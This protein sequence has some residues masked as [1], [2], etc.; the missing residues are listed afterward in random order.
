[1]YRITIGK[2]I[3]SV[4]SIRQQIA[5]F[6]IVKDQ[7]I[8]TDLNSQKSELIQIMASYLNQQATRVETIDKLTDLDSRTA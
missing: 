1:M 3:I 5:E 2:P 8:L 4:S 7:A 6:Q